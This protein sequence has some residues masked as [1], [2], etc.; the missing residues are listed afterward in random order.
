[1]LTT[2]QG[3]AFDVYYILNAITL[4]II[5]FVMLKSDIFSKKTAYLGLLAGLLMLVPST[6]GTTGIYF[7]FASLVPWAIFSVLVARR[8]FQL[9][10]S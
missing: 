7:G 9:G 1:M 8:L 3:T 6:A 5:S 2:F 4:I 10:K